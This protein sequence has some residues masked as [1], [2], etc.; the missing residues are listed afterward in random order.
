MFNL[1]KILTQQTA[2]LNRFACKR[3]PLVAT[4]IKGISTFPV[5]SSGMRFALIVCEDDPDIGGEENVGRVMIE[6]FK[7]NQ[8]IESKQFDQWTAIHAVSKPL[9]SLQKLC[10]Y[11]GI[12]MTGSRY[13]VNAQL[14]WML[15]LE[16]ALRGIRKHQE[17]EG[18]GYPKVFGICF[19]HQLIAKAFGGRVETHEENFLCSGSVKV[20]L[21]PEITDRVYFKQSFPKNRDHFNIMKLH[22][23]YVSRLPPDA[24]FAG[25]S[26][27]CKHEAI[28]YDDSIITLQGHPEVTPQG[29]MSRTLPRMLK[30][31]FIKDQD[32]KRIKGSAEHI[33]YKQL[34][35]FI[36]NFLK[37]PPAPIPGIVG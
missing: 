26:I 8:D 6:N 22:Q 4:K 31:G 35:Q 24:V 14:P 34:V 17:N 25:T 28:L 21:S 7:N 1:V 18:N 11:D 20:Y 29:L 15:N 10:S 23:D 19:S 27:H 37:S 36:L 16:R 33:D 2:P 12:V 32:V 13:C 30:M 3:N 9:P 5:Q